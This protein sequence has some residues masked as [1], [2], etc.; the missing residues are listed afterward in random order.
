MNFPI[1][2]DNIQTVS[3]LFNSK[4]TSIPLQDL[5]IHYARIDILEEDI[6]QINKIIQTVK[7]GKRLEGK[8]YTNG[9]LNREI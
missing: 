8:E 3:T 9:N 1:M 7:E 5:S 2:L 4:I 6:S